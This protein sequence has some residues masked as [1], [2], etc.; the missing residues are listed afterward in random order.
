MC[1]LV[2]FAVVNLISKSGDVPQFCMNFPL[3]SIEWSYAESW[4]VC[5]DTD[6]QEDFSDSS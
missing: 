4:V 3:L 2:S 5:N 1:N 6:Q